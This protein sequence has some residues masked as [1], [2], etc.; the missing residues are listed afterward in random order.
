MDG[1]L[2]LEVHRPLDGTAA[3]DIE[4]LTSLTRAIVAA[5]ARRRVAVDWDT[6]ERVF[7]DATGVPTRISIER[8]L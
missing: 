6:A 4:D 1:A 2:Y 8:R 7:E 5:T 3:K